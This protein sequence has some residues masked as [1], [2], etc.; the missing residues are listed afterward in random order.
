LK[1]ANKHKPSRVKWTRLPLIVTV[2]GTSI[3][4]AHGEG[5]D[6]P[7]ATIED[8]KSTKGETLQPV[9]VSASGLVR[10]ANGH[11]IAGATVYLREVAFMRWLMKPVRDGYTDI[12]QQTTTDAEA[13]SLSRKWPPSP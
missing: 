6:R 13:D 5:P 1:H 12:L 3:L 8:P 2:L 4:A 9:H 10:D 11:P 7:I